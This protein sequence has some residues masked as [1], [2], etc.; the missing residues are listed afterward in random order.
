MTAP[1]H[2]HKPPLDAL[3]RRPAAHHDAA[4]AAVVQHGWKRH[5][6]HPSSDGSLPT[7]PC[8]IR[9]LTVMSRGDAELDDGQMLPFVGVR[10]DE[11]EPAV[12]PLHGLSLLGIPSREGHLR[13]RLDARPLVPDHRLLIDK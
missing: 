12:A 8:R 13:S 2:L 11:P 9:T 4:L 3:A 1:S 5:P 6:A 7:L 10:H